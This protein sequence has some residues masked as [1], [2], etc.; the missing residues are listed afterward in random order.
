MDSD[1]AERIARTDPARRTVSAEPVP[2]WMRSVAGTWV[3]PEF[4]RPAVILEDKLVQELLAEAEALNG[5]IALFKA[6]CFDEIAKYRDAVA[7]RYGARTGGTRG[8]LTLHSFDQR[9]RVS[10]SEAD[11]LTFG[12]ELEAAKALIDACL[13]DWT[14]DGNEHVRVIVNQAFQVGEGKKIRVDRVLALRS[15]AIDDDR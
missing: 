6:K 5:L 2:G 3:N 1:F 13:L 9:L 15:L 11:T 8:G 10:I 7:A 4:V 14:K 12:G